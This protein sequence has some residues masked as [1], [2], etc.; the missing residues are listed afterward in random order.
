MRI[1]DI[2]RRSARNLR[3]AKARTILTSLAIGVGAFALTLTL[4]ASNG[5]QHFVDKIISDNFDP[6]ELI[7]AKD[8]AV[9][10]RGDTSKPKEY[11][12]SYGSYA[13][14]SGAPTQ[15]KQLT[16]EDIAKL[17]SYPEVEQV[18]E[19]MIVNL[20]Y[21]TRPD[22]KKYVATA[23]D[24]SPA[25]NPELL[26]GNIEKPLGGKKVLVP[27]AFVSTLGFA[28]AASAVGQKL[29]FAVRKPITQ[30][31]VEQSIRQ[32]LPTDA[33]AAQQLA[34]QNTVE[35]EYTI[36]AV[37]KKPTTSQPG[38]ELYFY[39][40]NE[41]AKALNDIANEGTPQYRKYLYSYVRVKDG[42]DN[43]KLKAVQDTLKK[44]GFYTQ[45]V[46]DTQQF[47]T[48]IINILKGIVV[49]FGAIAVIASVF[50]VV[51]TMYISVLQRTREIGLMKALGMPKR[52]IGHLF[53]FEAAWIGFLGGAIGSLGAYL[54][55]EAINP[56]ITEQLKLGEGEKLLIF[57][58]P[59]IAELIFFLILVA[60]FAGLLPARKAT[61]LDPIDALRT[62]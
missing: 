29:T 48:Q 12:D 35:I 5:V 17:K 37:L 8:E 55:G 33:G 21:V 62:E 38:T 42:Q 27:E 19:G 7:V 39:V 4:A 31:S 26:A 45:S 1:R 46:E 51:N 41:D 54:L 36:A 14:N 9:I 56:K 44:D 47:L 32:G 6:A 53:R 11:D 10:G 49:A 57:Q 34:S 13:T 60:V 52:D 30:A 28:D 58:F 3:Q 61:K 43:V 20:Q 16:E 22:Q 2:T 25:Q 40:G 23:I 50:G 18:R 59:Q 24:F 15:V